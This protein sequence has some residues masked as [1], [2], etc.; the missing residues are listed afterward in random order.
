MKNTGKEYELIVQRVFQSILNQK[1]VQ[2]IKVEHD[3]TLQG[4]D[5]THQIDVYWEFSDGISQYATIV[6]AK[7]YNSKVSKE[8]L[9]TFKSVIEDLPIH[10]KGIFVTKTGY[11][12][13]AKDVAKANGILLYELR[14]PTDEDWAGYIRDVVIHLKCFVPRYKNFRMDVDVQW[15]REQYGNIHPTLHIEGDPNMMFLYNTNQEKI[16]SLMQKINNLVSVQKVN[17]E[18]KK[19]ECV[20]SEPTFIDYGKEGIPLLKIKGLMFDVAYS[21]F[22]DTIVING[23]DVVKFILKNVLENKVNNID[24]SF[25]VHL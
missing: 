24:K 2:N 13:G 23:D 5:T 10:P 8:K 6:Q 15:F 22:D 19:I 16:C 7:D 18:S 25:N 17:D 3:I 12:K 9:L 4:K 14:Q 11:Q 1:A 20:F 21:T